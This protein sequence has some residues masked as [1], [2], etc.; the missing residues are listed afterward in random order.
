M[1]RATEHGQVVRVFIA[2]TFI[3]AMVTVEWALRVTDLASSAGAFLCGICFHMPFI[4]SKVV[5][6]IQPRIE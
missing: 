5:S 3:G 4:R 6:I 2:D 1:T